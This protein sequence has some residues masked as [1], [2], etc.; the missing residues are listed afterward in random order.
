MELS[1]NPVL[2]SLIDAIT[3]KEGGTMIPFHLVE[4]KESFFPKETIKSLNHLEKLELGEAISRGLVESTKRDYKK[5]SANKSAKGETLRWICTR[6]GKPQALGTQT[7]R[8]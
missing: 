6:N 8:M 5:L 2:V 3:V 1:V 7:L 4:N